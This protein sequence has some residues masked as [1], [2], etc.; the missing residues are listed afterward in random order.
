MAAGLELEGLLSPQGPVARRLPH[1]ERRPQQEELAREVGRAIRDGHHLLAEAGTGVGKSFAYLLPAILRAAETSSGPVVVS[2]RTIALQEQLERKDLPFL[3]AVLPLE[4]SSVVALGRNN[5]LCLRRMHRAIGD[6]RT[7][8][9]DLEAVEQLERIAEWS[10]TTREGVRNDLPFQP[11]PEVWEEV[12]AEHGN[13]LHQRCPHFEAC[14]YQ[15]GRRRM[16]TAQILVVNHSLYFADL[17]LRR[18]GASYLPDHKVVV[19]DEAHHLER[20]A[21][22]GLTLSISPGMVEWHV[23]RLLSRDG[24]RG[25]LVGVPSVAARRELDHVRSRAEGFFD[26]LSDRIE[27]RGTESTATVDPAEDI[28]NDLSGPLATLGAETERAAEALDSVDSRM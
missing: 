17:A 12:Q 13:C 15:R 10:A 9:P 22:E 4:W 6:R 1:Y 23:R 21:T 26:R 18:A 24:Q 25:L 20:I 3:A 8:F 28:E 27:R 5:Y 14:H 2:T 19:F 7:L 11:S 16:G